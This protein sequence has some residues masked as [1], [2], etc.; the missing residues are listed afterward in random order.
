MSGR[1]SSAQQAEVRRQEE[2][3][4][5]ARARAGAR[6]TAE[7]LA[8]TEIAV[9]CRLLRAHDELL[10]EATCKQVWLKFVQADALT[11][12]HEI[13][14]IVGRPT[15]LGCVMSRGGYLSHGRRWEEQGAR[16]SVFPGRG[17]GR[18]HKPKSGLDE[19]H[20][21]DGFDA[22]IDCDGN[23]G[24]QGNG[25]ELWFKDVL[26]QSTFMAEAQETSRF[27]LPAGQPF[28]TKSQRG[29]WGGRHLNVR[30]AVTMATRMDDPVGYARTVAAALE[31]GSE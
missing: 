8:T 7:L 30:D 20:W 23:A 18:R 16:V 12:R 28:R 27:I 31:A 19:A 4:E 22:W 29:Q 9:A 25:P 26:I 3:A 5:V 14:S 6:A 13:V 2:I 21:T 17:A 1:S 24:L 11:P 10:A 15:V